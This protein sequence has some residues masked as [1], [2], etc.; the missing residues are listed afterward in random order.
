MVFDNYIQH[1]TIAP[2]LIRIQ[3]DNDNTI[4]YDRI[5]IRYDT[6]R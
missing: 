2:N 5:R 3:Y 4:Q 1:K 6:I